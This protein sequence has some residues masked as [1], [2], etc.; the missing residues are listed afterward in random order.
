MNIGWDAKRA[1]HNRTGLGN[2]SRSLIEW[3]VNTYPEH[4]YYLF[5]PKPSTLFPF[6]RPNLHEVGPE[7]SL[8]RKFPSAWRSWWMS[9]SLRRYGINVYHGLSQELPYG[10]HRTGIPSV[11]TL[12]DLIFLAHPEQYAFFDRTIYAAKARYACTHADRILT[13]SQQTRNDIITR[14]RIPEE[15]ITVSHLSCDPRFSKKVAPETLTR[16]RVD[17]NLPDSFLLYVGSVI[18]RKN[19]MNLCRALHLIRQET[20]IPLVVIGQGGA[21]KKKVESYLSASGMS[22]RVIF[23]RDRISPA[24]MPRLDQALPAIFQSATALVYPSFYEGFGMPVLEALWSGTPVITSPRSSLPEVGGDAALYADPDDPAS[25]AEALRR[26]LG[27]TGL[28]DQLR[29]RGWEQAKK[30]TPEICGETVMNT[31]KSLC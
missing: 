23:L 18:E 24:D 31:Y 6:S 28:A 11:V 5:N 17:F 29:Q 20:A 12:H 16:I 27:E 8:H 26:I 15:K 13:I 4:Q 3:C 10:I 9:P 30:F 22:N 19:L 1:F 25:L 2:Y 14:W 21:Y 7:S